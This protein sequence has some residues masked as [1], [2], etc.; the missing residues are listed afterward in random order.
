MLH[1]PDN[2]PLLLYRHPLGIPT[3]GHLPTFNYKAGGLFLGGF[4]IE[5]FVV[6]AVHSLKE[7]DRLLTE[8][9]R[10]TGGG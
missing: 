9:R 4:S 6:A 5:W 2:V 8:E 1:L 10:V 3:L 7:S